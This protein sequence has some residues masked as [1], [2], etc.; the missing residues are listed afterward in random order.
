MVAV[1]QSGKLQSE[2]YMTFF[3]ADGKAAIVAS[4]DGKT[5]KAVAADVKRVPAMVVGI[6]DGKGLWAGTQ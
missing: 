6:S 3:Q 1:A 2:G 5:W 4:E